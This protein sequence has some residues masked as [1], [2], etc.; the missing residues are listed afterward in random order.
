MREINLMYLFEPASA[1]FI[2]GGYKDDCV[3]WLA[4]RITQINRE[5]GYLTF[6]RDIWHRPR[7]FWMPS[8]I[9][10]LS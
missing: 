9:H 3:G 10:Q 7:I 4:F 6:S 8:I 2:I 5:N 1:R